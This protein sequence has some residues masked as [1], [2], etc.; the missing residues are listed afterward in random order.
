MEEKIENINYEIWN[1]HKG[2]KQICQQL[3]LI[4]SSVKLLPIKLLPDETH[5]SSDTLTIKF[6]QILEDQTVSLMY[7]YV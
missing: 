6:Y 2:K 4:G 1:W 5:T 7:S 3:V